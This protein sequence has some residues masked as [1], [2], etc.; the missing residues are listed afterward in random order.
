MFIKYA[1]NLLKYMFVFVSIYADS[2]QYRFRTTGTK[3]VQAGTH[4]ANHC[5]K[6]AVT[7]RRVDS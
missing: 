6:V 2:Y 5:G 1:Y 7:Q 4:L 3:M